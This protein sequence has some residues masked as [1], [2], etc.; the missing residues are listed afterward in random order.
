MNP[1]LTTELMPASAH[2]LGSSAPN[3]FEAANRKDAGTLSN[4]ELETQTPDPIPE[5]PSPIP[6][7]PERLPAPLTARLPSGVAL[8]EGQRRA[9]L[10]HAY[11]AL[12]LA[13][14]EAGE[15]LSYERASRLLSVPLATLWRL[16]Q[17]REKGLP[18]VPDF[19]KGGRKKK[20]ADTAELL[21]LD[22]IRTK[23]DTLY[24]ATFGASSESAASGR[25]TGKVSVALQR[26]AEEPECP[27]ALAERLRAGFQPKPLVHYFRRITPEV[28]ARLRGKKNFELNGLVSR[29][30]HTIRLRDGSRVQLLSGCLIEFDD[31]S[32]NQPFYVEMPDGQ[33][34]LSRQ[35]LYARDVHSGRWLGV[36]LVARPREAYR[37]EDILRFLRRLMM[38]YGKF[39][40]LRLERGIWAARSLK[41]WKVSADGIE[42]ENIERPDM[43]LEE[44]AK[45]QSGLEAIGVTIH[46]VTS[47]HRKGALE[48][49]FN[50]LQTV[51]A[52]YTTDLV[53][54]GRYA[55]EFDAAAKRV[56]QARAGSHTPAVLGFAPVDVLADRIEQ[57]M[58][59]INKRARGG[60]VQNTA[61]AIW[62]RDLATRPLPP[63]E[64]I[65]LAAF[66]PEVRER[67]IAGGRI[68]LSVEGVAHDF[69]ADVFAR[70]GH[71]YRVYVRF[72]P[73]EPTL[74]AAIYNRENSGGSANTFEL[75]DG[76]FICFARWEM[77]GPQLDMDTA[78]AGLQAVTTQAL[79]GVG[80][81]HDDGYARRRSQEKFVRTAFR[82]LPR[83]G[84]PAM[85]SAEVRDGR[86]NFA[87]VV[88]TGEK[89]EVRGENAAPALPPS[90]SPLAP[91]RGGLPAAP[92]EQEFSR[93]QARLAEEAE[94]ARALRELQPDQ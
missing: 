89:G 53:N 52:T 65:D 55:G 87:R 22:A 16:I 79:Y 20:H 82:A 86:G 76:D 41:G 9:Q 8:L 23:L 51:L 92:T 68:T 33:W 6:H 64:H 34:L 62:T 24:I 15:T 74:G 7:P 71:G 29:R 21:E 61:D 94:A 28:E 3:G 77:P 60:D 18:L 69:R 66:L 72:D 10:L 63:L 75:R 48:S 84:Q 43:T 85:K 36:E 1:D 5:T 11:D 37:A 56:R 73:G 35:G 44:K 26:F 78:P 14:I 58:A 38:I 67:A 59:F 39:D 30:D 81:E 47:A 40:V 80:A 4:A 49:S 32:V 45:L 91:R 46:Y 27:P 31:M 25:R 70:L 12:V 57:A 19:H 50:Y 42:E 2:S 13:A 90:P 93:R 17:R 54:V 88:S 83:P